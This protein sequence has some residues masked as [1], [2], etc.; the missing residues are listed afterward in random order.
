MARRPA[1]C[2][3][4]VVAMFSASTARADPAPADRTLAQ[5]LFEQGRQFMDAKNYAAACPKFSESERLDPSAGTLLNLAVCHERAGKLATAWAEYGDAATAARRANEQDRA[6]FAD[7]HAKA[8]E[9]KLAHLTI[10]V[11]AGATFTVKLDG[12]EIGTAAWGTLLP[13]DVGAHHV[14]VLR[15]GRKVWETTQEIA[16]DGAS[17]VVNIPEDASS[18]PSSESAPSTEES[19]SG[20]GSKTIGWIALGVGGAGL[21]VGTIFGGMALGTAGTL[22]NECPSSS[23]CPAS[24]QGDISALHTNEWMADIGF[25]VGLVGA[26]IGTWLLLSEPS[27]AATQAPDTSLRVEPV[28][29]IGAMGLR[30]RFQ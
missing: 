17:A 18:E 23:T 9:P 16:S 28:V 11:P 2:L 20:N 29:G 14:V 26:G 6:T 4:L 27:G 19:A 1:A 8:L 25:A 30:G 12:A 10:R 3:A 21:V 15:D 24:A 13:V 7:E 22:K 5:S